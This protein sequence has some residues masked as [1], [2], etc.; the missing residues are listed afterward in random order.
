MHRTKNKRKNTR[1]AV[2]EDITA[3]LEMKDPLD[4]RGQKRIIVKGNVKDLGAEGMFFVS[5]ESIPVDA[6]AYIVIDFNPGQ[7]GAWTLA[8]KGKT[9]RKAP[10]GVGIRFSSVDLRKMQ[11]CI[12]AR[13][14]HS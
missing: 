10:E 5:N 11:R 4:P 13:M 1:S 6:K 2:W 9:V 12:M 14:N 7:P 3:T 8:A